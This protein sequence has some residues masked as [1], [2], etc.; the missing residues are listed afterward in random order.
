MELRYRNV[1][2]YNC[3]E[4]GHYVGNCI[5]EKVCF[6]CGI[7]GHHMNN[8]G[9]RGKPIPM[10]QYVGS[11]N[12]GLGFFHVNVVEKQACEW[13]NLKNC[14]L[15]VVTH[16]EIS[17]KELEAKMCEAWDATWPWQVRQLEDRKFL[18]RFPP[19]KKVMDLIDIPSIN[20]KEG[21]DTERVTVKIIGWEGDISDVGQLAECWVQIRGI[22]PRWVSLDVIAQIAKTLGLLLDVDWGKIF[23]SFYEVVRIQLAV[24]SVEKIPEE[25]IY[26]MKKK[27]YWLAF[28]V[29]RDGAGGG[30]SNNDDDNNDKGNADG[31]MDGEQEGFDGLEDLNEMQDDNT[32]TPGA[33]LGSMPPSQVTKYGAKTCPV[34][35]VAQSNSFQPLVDFGLLDE[36]EVDEEFVVDEMEG[37]TAAINGVTLEETELGVEKGQQ[38]EIEKACENK[39]ED[40]AKGQMSA[41]A[42]CEH[43]KE[44]LEPTPG[45]AEMM[46]KIKQNKWGPVF[47]VRQSDRIIRDGKSALDKAKELLEKKNLEKPAFAEYLAEDCTSAQEMDASVQGAMA[48]EDRRLVRGAGE[49]SAGTSPNRMAMK[50]R[51]IGTKVIGP[52]T[53]EAYGDVKLR[54]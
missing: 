40:I 33:Q 24:K 34:I 11:A 38:E 26:V 22:P 52:G 51:R 44:T 8:C 30:N 32:H 46:K 18:V 10:A 14:G 54:A 2:C 29:E 47:P 53:P 45:E 36:E 42:Q 50:R 20:L 41:A 35:H 6:M 1:V 48:G 7:P 5:K 4:P 21:N 17:L 28:E 43:V 3:G 9:L 15:I 19:H 37:V 16:G 13:L 25:R 23:K 39:D 49:E 12:S 27:F 31:D